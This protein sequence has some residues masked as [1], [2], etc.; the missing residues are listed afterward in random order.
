MVAAPL[1]FGADGRLAG[2]GHACDQIVPFAHGEM[3]SP[4]KA[5]RQS[6]GSTDIISWR[7]RAGWRGTT[8][9]RPGRPGQLYCNDA[10][11]YVVRRLRLLSQGSAHIWH[12]CRLYATF[13]ERQKSR[14]SV[15]PFVCHSK[16]FFCHSTSFTLTTSIGIYDEVKQYLLRLYKGAAFGRQPPSLTKRIL[17]QVASV[18]LVGTPWRFH[19]GR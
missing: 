14:S 13:R 9:P 15:V 19:A 18:Q 4:T 11:W 6:W 8:D 1:Q 17:H 2:A 5:C 7:N 3:I 10:C 16:I 12:L